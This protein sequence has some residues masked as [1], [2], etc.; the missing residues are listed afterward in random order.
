MCRPR[1]LLELINA[2]A[3]RGCARAELG[4]GARLRTPPDVSRTCCLQVKV[5]AKVAFRAEGWLGARRG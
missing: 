2:G 1:S 5:V 4:V 3:A